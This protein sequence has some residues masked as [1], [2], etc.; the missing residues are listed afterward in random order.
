MLNWATVK[1]NLRELLN[2]FMVYLSQTMVVFLVA[3]FSSNFLTDLAALEAFGNSKVNVSSISEFKFTFLA[4][5]LWCGVLCISKEM[6]GGS[7]LGVAIRKALREFP[8]IIYM[9]GSTTTGV[10]MAIAIY[11]GNHPIG[12]W[13]TGQWWSTAGLMT[14]YCFWMGF[15]L[16]AAMLHKFRTEHLASENE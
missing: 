1:E 6:L 15:A 8:R 13:T 2:E 9:F 16:N 11:V 10:A 14:L 12:P 7:L 3:V 5:V 4:L